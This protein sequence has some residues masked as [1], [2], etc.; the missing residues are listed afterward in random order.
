MF[1]CFHMFLLCTIPIEE[2]FILCSKHHNLCFSYSCLSLF[3]SWVVY[4][5]IYFRESSVHSRFR[6]ICLRRRRKG[7][8]F[9]LCEYCQLSSILQNTFKSLPHL[10]FTSIL[11]DDYNYPYFMHEEKCGSERLRGRTKIQTYVCWFKASQYLSLLKLGTFFFFGYIYG[12]WKFP[13]QGSNPSCSYDLCYNA[14][15]SDP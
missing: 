12:I 3:S 2:F 5:T 14:A 11:W 8:V 13:G 7:I 6:N 15:M 10:L 1:S 4:I 9:F